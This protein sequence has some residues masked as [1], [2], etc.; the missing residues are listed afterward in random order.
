[1]TLNGRAWIGD[2]VRDETVKREGIVTDVRQGTYVLRP[3][4]GTAPEWTANSDD[5][6]TITVPRED[7]QH[8]I[9]PE[10]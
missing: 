10:R 2:Q 3:L 1:M 7:R 6:L 5:Q 4:H 9:P 8:S